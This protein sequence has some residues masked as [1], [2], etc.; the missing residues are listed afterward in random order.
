MSF[1][2]FHLY[3]SANCIFISSDEKSSDGNHLFSESVRYSGYF[4][5][6]GKFMKD[7]NHSC[8]IPD[9][10]LKKVLPNIRKF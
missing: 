5:I 6:E 1:L 10:F 3:E 9:I 4:R 2:G 7:A 8:L